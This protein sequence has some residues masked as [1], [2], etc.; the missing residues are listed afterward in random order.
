MNYQPGDYCHINHDGNDG[1][2][3]NTRRKKKSIQN[4]SSSP[5]NQVSNSN[6]IPHATIENVQDVVALLQNHNS[7]KP[8][9]PHA[10]P[11]HIAYLMVS[12]VPA[13]AI[14]TPLNIVDQM[15]R[16]NVSVPMRDILAIP[17]QLNYYNKN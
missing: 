5:S 13:K 11:I 14:Y 2:A 17:S 16:T 1:I 9:E 6:A 15:K 7:K 4:T 10:T 8:K 12:K 3:C